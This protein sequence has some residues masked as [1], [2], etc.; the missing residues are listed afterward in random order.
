MI[1]LVAETERPE[2]RRYLSL[3]P[4]TTVKIGRNQEIPQLW[5][6]AY[7]LM[8]VSCGC[9]SRHFFL[10]FCHPSALTLFVVSF[11]LPQMNSHFFPF[12]VLLALALVV[13]SKSKGIAIAIGKHSFLLPDNH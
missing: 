3:K 5:D 2:E 11:L 9:L 12:L 4:P 10:H 7:N 13:Y 6:I 8:F 1:R